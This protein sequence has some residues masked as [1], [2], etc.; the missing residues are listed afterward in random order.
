M[1]SRTSSV[2][3][4]SWAFRADQRKGYDHKVAVTPTGFIRMAL[5]PVCTSGGCP[6]Q[7]ETVVQ[8]PLSRRE[9]PGTGASDRGLIHQGRVSQQHGSLW[10]LGLYSYRICLI[11]VLWMWGEASWGYKAGRLYMANSLPTWAKLNWPCE[12][13]SLVPVPV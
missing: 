10:A 1:E 7:H 5:P 13:L 3:G 12:R 11:C 8:A 9:L 4:R 6:S 2:W